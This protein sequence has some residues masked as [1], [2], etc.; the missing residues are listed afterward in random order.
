MSPSSSAWTVIG[1]LLTVGAIALLLRRSRQAGPAYRWLA[2]AAAAWGAAFV[3]Q[4]AAAGS[5]MPTAV[6]LSLTDLLALIGL[7][8]LVVGLV[9]LA[10]AGRPVGGLGHLVDGCLLS[11]GVFAIG[12]IALLRPAYAATDVGA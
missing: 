7:P 5:V 4:L 2:A 12:W 9:K 10:P 6:Q 11:L 1:A 3:A 8:P